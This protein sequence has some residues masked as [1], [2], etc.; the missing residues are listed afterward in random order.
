MIGRHE[1]MSRSD[2]VKSTIKEN[3]EAGPWIIALEGLKSSNVS[4]SIVTEEDLMRGFGSGVPTV[5]KEV[6]TYTLT[7]TATSRD[8]TTIAT[9]AYTVT[10][11]N[12]IMVPAGTE[13]KTITLAIATPQGSGDMLLPI[14]LTLAAIIAM[15]LAAIIAMLLILSYLRRKR[16]G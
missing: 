1:H 9:Y 2:L 6:S 7:V 10:T 12:Y 11:T 8:M 13:Y 16:E 14:T 3:I 15:L 4:I 5:I